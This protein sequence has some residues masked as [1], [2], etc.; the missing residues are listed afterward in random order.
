MLYDPGRMV[1]IAVRGRDTFL[2]ARTPAELA[3]KIT[4]YAPRPGAE[5]RT[6]PLGVVRL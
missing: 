6:L 1:W 4:A 5:P 3:G 2:T